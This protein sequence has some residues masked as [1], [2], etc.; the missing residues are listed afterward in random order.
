MGRYTHWRSV[1]MGSPSRAPAQTASS[2]SGTVSQRRLQF[3]ITG[4]KATVTSLAFSPDGRRICLW[5]PRRHRPVVERRR[6]P[7]T[8]GAHR[9]HGE[10][11][12]IAFHPLRP[13][14]AIGTRQSRQPTGPGEIRIWNVE[15]GPAAAVIH[16]ASRCGQ[17]CRLQPRRSTT[18]LR[19]RRSNDR[20]LARQST[21]SQCTRLSLAPAD[22]SARTAN[23]VL[24]FRD[25]KTGQ[26]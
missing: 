9:E 19:Q 12:T 10:V 18:G 23:R 17:L 25:V 11:F 5:Q 24:Q 3:R 6:R 15:N 26:D 22:V 14:L 1:L 20:S 4:H 2:A 7:E 8:A 16:R 21:G 13:E